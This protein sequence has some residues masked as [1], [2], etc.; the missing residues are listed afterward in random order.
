MCRPALCS[1]VTH[2]FCAS[3]GT[4]GL[5][6]ADCGSSIIT[7]F[8]TVYAVIPS[9]CSSN[10]ARATRRSSPC[11]RM[12]STRAVHIYCALVQQAGRREC[13][14]LLRLHATLPACTAHVAGPP[15]ACGARTRGEAAGGGRRACVRSRRTM[16]CGSPSTAVAAISCTMRGRTCLR[17]AGGVPSVHNPGRAL[18]QRNWHTAHCAPATGMRPLN[19]L[20]TADPWPKTYTYSSARQRTVE[21]A[22]RRAAGARRAPAER[23]GARRARAWSAAAAARA[24]R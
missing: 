15:Q 23:G 11:N 9:A 6:H 20:R 13:Q 8:R 14:P 4:A 18:A 24:L 2:T 22:G 3:A 5:P 7:Y 17:T 10:A 12:A 1:S 16:P 19:Q 21:R